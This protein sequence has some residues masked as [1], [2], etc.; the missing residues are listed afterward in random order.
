[1]FGKKVTSTEVARKYE[2]LKK[3]IGGYQMHI[4]NIINS[5]DKKIVAFREKYEFYKKRKEPRFAA[6]YLKEA[7]NLRMLKNVLMTV[8]MGLLAVNLRLDTMK[9]VVSALLE[10]K[11]STKVINQVIEDARVMSDSFS[12]YYKSF[13]DGYIDLESIINIPEIDLANFV[14]LQDEDATKIIQAVERKIGEELSKRFPNIPEQLDQILSDDPRKGVQKLY[15]MLATDGGVYES[16]AGRYGGYTPTRSRNQIKNSILRVNVK[17]LKTV[18]AR[19]LEK[20]EVAI[21][22]YIIN[23][24]RGEF[25]YM[26]IYQLAKMTR[27]SPETVLEGLYNLAEAGLIS[28]THGM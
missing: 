1:M 24:K 9:V 18:D 7:N 19:K 11:E 23:I 22:R 2:M 13:I 10:F 26:D 8:D 3:E 14:S 6:L 20:I 5:I 17:K 25:G 21:L 15:E 12:N 27:S 28:F 4:R 16:G